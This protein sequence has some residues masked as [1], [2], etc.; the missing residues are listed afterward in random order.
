MKHIIKN[1]TKI[2]T[3]LL[4]ILILNLVLLGLF[5]NPIQSKAAPDEIYTCRVCRKSHW[6]GLTGNEELYCKNKTFSEPCVQE[7]S[8]LNAKCSDDS[9]AIPN[10]NTECMSSGGYCTSNE[11]SENFIDSG[12]MGCP[13][14]TYLRCCLPKATSLVE[15]QEKGGVCLPDYDQC[16]QGFIESGVMGCDSIVIGGPSKCCLPEATPV[17][18]PV[19]PPVVTPVVTPANGVSTSTEFP[20]DNPLGTTSDITTLVKNILNFLIVLAIPISAILI[21]YAGYLY[22]TSAG[23]EEK[24]KTAQKTLIWALIGFAIVLI[25]SSVP[26]IIQE[27]LSGTT[28]T[29]TTTNTLPPSIQI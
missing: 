16:S 18:P 6:S 4:T 15:C 19:V 21:V 11:C 24:V 2:N 13:S 20:F 3:V 26:A 17:V 25:A 12:L 10:L 14:G 23:N 9:S 28:T 29:T 1:S 8:T 27:F 22:I 7:C 5:L